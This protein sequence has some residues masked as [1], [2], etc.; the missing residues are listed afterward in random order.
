MKFVVVLEQFLLS[1]YIR[2]TYLFLSRKAKCS[3]FTVN[4]ATSLSFRKINSV[5]A[6]ILHEIEYIKVRK[7]YIHYA[8]L[9]LDYIAKLD[10]FTNNL[11]TFLSTL[12]MYKYS[13]RLCFPDL[14]LVFEL[15]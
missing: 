1:K 5:T 6:N 10:R 3:H 9:I 14:I 8:N 12:Y 4:F 15:A 2:Y 13:K 11:K 7:H